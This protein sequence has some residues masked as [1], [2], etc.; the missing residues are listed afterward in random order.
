M[1]RL[2]GAVH[3]GKLASDVK[4]ELEA[5]SS[6]LS[7]RSSAEFN[8]PHSPVQ[9]VVIQMKTACIAENPTCA[10]L[11]DFHIETAGL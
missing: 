1:R 3:G 6:V 8:V 9:N 2:E 5:F 11:A 7:V 4:W 10:Q